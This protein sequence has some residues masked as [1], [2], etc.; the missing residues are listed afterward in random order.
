MDRI[1][2]DHH[3]TI[4]YSKANRAKW[5]AMERIFG[6]WEESYAELPLY[7]DALRRSNPGTT[8]F[9]EGPVIQENNMG[10]PIR[11]FERVFWAFGPAL[12]AFKH[13][14]PLVCIDGTHLYGKYKGNLLIAT[15][16]DA[17]NGLLPIA[18]A[19]VESENRSSWTFFLW[20]LFFSVGCINNLCV[21]S[22]RHLGIIAGMK[23]IEWLDQV[24]PQ[25]WALCYDDGRRHGTMTTNRAESMNSV[26]K[27]VRGL[28]ITAIL[29]QTFIRVSEYFYTRRESAESM[30]GEHV[31]SMQQHLERT[32]HD[33]RAMLVRR[34]DRSEFNVQDKNAVMYIVFLY[35]DNAE[36]QCHVPKLF[37]YPCAH[38]IAAC[39]YARISPGRYVSHWL[40]S[41]SYRHT[42]EPR[43]HS[44]DDKS[45]WPIPTEN[46]PIFIPPNVRRQ[47]GRPVST[48]RRMHMDSRDPSLRY[49]CS[50][51]HEK[52]HRKNKCPRRNTNAGN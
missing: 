43:F 17:E 49:T 1:R 38:V 41:E 22:D 13:C 50:I 45:R 29:Q 15:A 27:G 36:C 28:P 46:D 48:R 26:L 24:P 44:V 8:V 34:L 32:A 52:G 39:E 16:C 35:S 9:F 40:S 11:Q 30:S 10:R 47:A 5:K 7:V 4:S 37:H 21:I 2:A 19:I 3:Y 42:Y 12:E 6:N 23:D 51:C 18:F 25:T 14:R 31:P 20:N 33:A